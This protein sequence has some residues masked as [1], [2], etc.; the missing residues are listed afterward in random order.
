MPR[1]PL[2]PYALSIL[3][4]LLACA[5]PVAAWLVVLRVTE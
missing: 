2:T 4:P 1:N 3:A 5:V